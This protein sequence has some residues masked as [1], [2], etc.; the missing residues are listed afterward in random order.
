MSASA[1]TSNRRTR[2]ASLRLRPPPKSEAA[3]EPIARAATTH[4]EQLLGYNARRAALTLIARFM[5]DLAEHDLRPADFSV[6]SALNH[7]PGM[8]SRQ[9]CQHLN[10]LPPNFVGL[11]RQLMQ[12]GWVRKIPHPTDGRA[13]G[14]FLTPA[15][16]RLMTQA[17]AMAL[18]SDR[19]ASSMLS[20]TERKTLIRLLQKIYL[21]DE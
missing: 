7:H 9:L 13:V 16:Q 17:E 3:A 6:L 2:V 4:L 19:E 1:G 12:K 21:R 14:L 18:Q 20:E 5:E 11:L 8:T 15:G 10:I